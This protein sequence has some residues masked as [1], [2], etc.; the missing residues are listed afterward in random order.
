MKN[1]KQLTVAAVLLMLFSLKVSAGD[2]LKVQFIAVH[3]GDASYNEVLDKSEFPNFDFY[4]ADGKVTGYTESKK[5]I[6]NPEYLMGWYGKVPEKMG[7]SAN[8]RGSYK[9]YYGFPYVGGVVYVIDRNGTITYQSPPEGIDPD[10]MDQYHAIR[11]AVNK[12]I[13]R[14]RK[15][16]EGKILKERKREYLKQAPVGELE[17]RK[18]CDVDKDGEGLIEWPVPDI[19]VKNAKGEEKG[20]LELTKGKATVLVMYTLNGVTW[21]K[22]NN[23][24]KIKAE[25]KGSKLLNPDQY[26]KK[27]EKEFEK[28]AD[29]D[30]GGFGNAMKFMGKEAAKSVSNRNSVVDIWSAEG[31]LPSQKKMSAYQY[32]LNSLKFVDKHW[33]EK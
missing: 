7:F 27:S 3:F 28:D 26:A 29:E 31:D 15:G 22:G 32:F 20:L 12:E 24:G 33:G 18:G 8:Y 21:K 19:K 10:K 17:P 1:F 23:K 13:R 16:K 14:A 25:W 6:G 30:K 5:P 2:D 4:T 11:N 9:K